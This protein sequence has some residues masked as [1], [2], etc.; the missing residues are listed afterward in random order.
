[1]QAAGAS[2][3]PWLDVHQRIDDH[4]DD[5]TASPKSDGQLKPEE[6]IYTKRKSQRSA[7]PCEGPAEVYLSERDTPQAC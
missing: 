4:H 6:S 5:Q 2:G 3:R 7:G 1:M